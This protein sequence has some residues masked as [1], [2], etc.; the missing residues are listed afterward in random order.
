MYM[1]LVPM[2]KGNGLV[3][4][5][6]HFLK[7]PFGH[8]LEP[9]PFQFPAI[10]DGGAEHKAQRVLPAQFVLFL[11]DLELLGDLPWGLPGQILAV[12]DFGTFLL[13]H[14]V[15]HGGRC[16]RYGLSHSYHFLKFK[17]CC[18]ISL[19]SWAV[20]SANLGFRFRIPLWVRLQDAAPGFL[21]LIPL[22][23]SF[24]DSS[25]G[26]LFWIPHGSP[27]LDSCSGFRS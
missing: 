20:S 14:P 26:F 3:L 16:V 18:R 8:F 5:K 12:Y 1:F 27:L 11:D 10:L 6:V 25:S 22:V 7:E 19:A 15:A 13:V 23:D 2:D 24:L 17:R 9:F 21:F 4:L